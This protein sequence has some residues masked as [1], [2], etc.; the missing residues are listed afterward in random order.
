MVR[1]IRLITLAPGHFHA[2]L[3]QKHARPGI[4]P[5]THIYAPLDSDTLA[6]VSRIARFNLRP[7]DP[8]AWDIELHACS[9]YLERFVREQPG[10]TVV[11]SG[12][13]QPKIA[14]MQAAVDNGLHVLADKP[15]I[16]DPADFSTLQQLLA[17]AEL[18][19]LIVWDILTERLEITNRL[20]RELVRDAEIF[21]SWQAGTP[22]EP[23]L[24]LRSV[25]FLNKRVSGEPLVRP[26]W[27]FDRRIAGEALADV[28]T[29]LADLAIGLVA[30]DQA[31]DF[32]TDIHMISATQQP[33]RISE[34]Q[35]CQV[36]RLPG[37]VPELEPYLHGGQLL[38]CGDQTV[39]FRLHGVHVR[40]NTVWEWESPGHDTHE[41]TARGSRSIISIRQ[42]P[43]SAPELYV[44]ATCPH[45]HTDLMKRLRQKCLSIQRE[46]TGLSVADQGTAGHLQIPPRWRS[47]HEDHFARVMDDYIRYFQ[48]PQSI[49]AWE[50]PNALARYFITTQAV[51]LLRASH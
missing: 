41:C 22:E 47:S 23:A 13:N 43:Y 4:D 21:G 3:V 49:P 44:S 42:Q 32:Q 37:F 10:N 40:L 33:L 38:Y 50:R 30:P 1:L 27:W 16:I 29:H 2:A 15:W 19:E 26:W 12:R 9:D 35:F 45:E 5:R 28:G 36:T 18:R 39:N 34:E 31:V 8:T 14:W 11:L 51:A 24:T 25:H 7:D 46:F 17:K 6:H 20:Q 48:S